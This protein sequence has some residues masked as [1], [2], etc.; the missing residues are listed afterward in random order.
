MR[1]LGMADHQLSDVAVLLAGLED[2]AFRLW[3]QQ[4][5]EIAALPVT[6]SWPR[7]FRLHQRAGIG[8]RILRLVNALRPFVV[9]V[10]ARRG[11]LIVNGDG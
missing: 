11:R 6:R 9:R 10:V 5:D 8:A 1:R 3:S 2:D 4:W 7:A